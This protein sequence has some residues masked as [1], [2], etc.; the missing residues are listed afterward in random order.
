MLLLLSHHVFWT[1]RVPYAVIVSGNTSATWLVE[2]HQFS[3]GCQIVGQRGRREV[4]G[5]YLGGSSGHHR[6]SMSAD[7]TPNSVLGQVVLF[8]ERLLKASKLQ[9]YWK[10][11]V[12][13]TIFKTYRF[14][15]V[16][17]FPKVFNFFSVSDL[18]RKHLW[19]LNFFGLFLPRLLFAVPRFT[20]YKFILEYVH[21]RI[22]SLPYFFIQL[23]N[24]WNKLFFKKALSSMSA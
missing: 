20:L 3:P 13:T 19:L 14:S 21:N 22:F 24:S 7:G 12:K 9:K 8:T 17:C 6:G 23:S 11:F 1:G 18:K 5:D 15:K 16:Y 2:R 10:Y 4:F